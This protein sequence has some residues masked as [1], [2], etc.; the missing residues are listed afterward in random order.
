VLFR[1]GRFIDWPSKVFPNKN[2]P[3]V[4]GILGKDPFSGA[5]DQIAKLR[6]I[7][8]RPIVIRRFNSLRDF[9]PCQILF[10]PKTI[11]STVQTAAI[12]KLN[13]QPVLL[14]GEVPSFT[15]QGGTLN[16]I[17]EDDSVRFEINAE[18]AKRQRLSIDAKMLQLASIVTDKKPAER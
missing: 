2:A 13:A 9:R 11:S 8:D 10:V 5:L 14:V 16:F 17:L 4:I 12:K 18:I 7:D 6:K 15:R 1:S 3:F